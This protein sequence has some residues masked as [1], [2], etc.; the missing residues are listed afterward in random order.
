MRP[1]A[2]ADD[3][4]DLPDRENGMGGCA[5]GIDTDGDGLIDCDD[6][7]CEDQDVCAPEEGCL[8]VEQE[9]GCGDIV[10]GNNA[11]GVNVQESWC[12][13]GGYKCC[14]WLGWS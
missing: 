12:S 7:D 13:V 4:D 11:D 6:P 14:W 10:L 1:A 2:A 8:P 9:L 5:D 3:D